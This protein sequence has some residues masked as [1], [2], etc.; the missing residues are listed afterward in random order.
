MKRYITAA[1]FLVWG[2]IASATSLD[3][4]REA[5]EFDSFRHP[6]RHEDPDQY[7]I[8]MHRAQEAKEEACREYRN[9]IEVRR[10][11][12]RTASSYFEV[13]AEAERK[14]IKDA[15]DAPLDKIDISLK[16]ILSEL[17]QVPDVV[18]LGN[19]RTLQL[20]EERVASEQKKL[21]LLATGWNS[22][23][24]SP[25][26]SSLRRLSELG[27]SENL[28]GHLRDAIHD[29]VRRFPPY[30][31]G[32]GPAPRRQL[33]LAVQRT[34]GLKDI[35]A[36]KYLKYS[37]AIRQEINQDLK[38][39]LTA[40]L[41]GAQAKAFRLMLLSQF[42]PQ[43]L[44]WFQ[45]AAASGACQL[46]KELL[47]AQ[48]DVL[49]EAGR[50][51]PI[52]MQ[53]VFIEELKPEVDS[54]QQALH[55]LRCDQPKDFSRLKEMVAV[56]ESRLSNDCIRAEG[57]VQQDAMEVGKD[58]ETWLEYKDAFADPADVGAFVNLG[59]HLLLKASQVRGIC[60]SRVP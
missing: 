24:L 54:R 10:Q 48:V 21:D 46:A 49:T 52:G 36:L 43:T 6:E 42:D 47:S 9:L 11:A 28:T 35:F 32:N 45:L 57:H 13:A 18:T 30:V 2:S 59:Q 51:A 8:D 37:E 58:L 1:L 23:F 25:P 17:A 33:D 14:R 26:D 41:V 39:G 7:E 53:S 16:T 38:A 19:N 27:N 15:V 20:L 22:Y 34:S 5:C 56:Y 3:E 12:V 4:A 44:P 50:Q 55:A 31:F 40:E 29:F 60:Q